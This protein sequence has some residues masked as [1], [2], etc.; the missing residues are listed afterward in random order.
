MSRYW[1]CEPTQVWSVRLGVDCA[2]YAQ[3]PL[4]AVVSFHYET[5]YVATF[6]APFA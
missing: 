4:S 2:A 5:A 6:P 1:L 3:A